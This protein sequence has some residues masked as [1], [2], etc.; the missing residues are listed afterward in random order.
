MDGE[1]GAA[2]PSLAMVMEK[3]NATLHKGEPISNCMSVELTENTWA[4]Y[5]GTG[6]WPGDFPS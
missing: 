5:G 3:P 6:P 1:Q 2:G 4:V